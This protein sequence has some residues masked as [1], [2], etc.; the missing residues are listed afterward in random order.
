[1]CVSVYVHVGVGG[2]YDEHS[3]NPHMAC[4]AHSSISVLWVRMLS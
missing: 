4:M 1:M 2:C 3:V